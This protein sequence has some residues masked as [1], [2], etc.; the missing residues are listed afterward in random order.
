MQAQERAS[1]HTTQRAYSHTSPESGTRK[2]VIDTT[3][4]IN[5]PF[6]VVVPGSIKAKASG[7]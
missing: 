5:K 7:I 3:E 1:E 2:S 4:L 6:A